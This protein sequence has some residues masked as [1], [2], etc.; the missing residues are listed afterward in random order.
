MSD[1]TIAAGVLTLGAAICAGGLGWLI[2]TAQRWRFDS[3]VAPAKGSAAKG[4]LYAFTMGM[5][6]WEKESARIHRVAYVRGVAF[7]L[8]IFLGV[9][10]LALTP[11]LNVLPLLVRLSFS[12]IMAAAAI[13]GLPGFWL[14]F[15]DRMLR[16][17]S[18]PDDYA[19][20]TLATLF[21]V[22]GSFCAAHMELLP[23]FWI[24]SGVTLAYT[25]FSKL[26]HFIYFFFARGF[27][28]LMFGYRGILK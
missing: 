20:L 21:L 8:G 26:R 12:A 25:P 24:V 3:D 10:F 11:W 2:V 6:P 23:L 22:S 15:H 28:G 27:F 9:A 4:I 19:A 5:L 13:A 17:V 1:F 16:A 18:T 14:R 7:H